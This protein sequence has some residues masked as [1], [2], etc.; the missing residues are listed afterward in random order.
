MVCTISH[1]HNHAPY[2]LWST[3]EHKAGALYYSTILVGLTFIC[4]NRAD[5]IRDKGDIILVIS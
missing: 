3:E 1:L 2:Y 5:D 4:M